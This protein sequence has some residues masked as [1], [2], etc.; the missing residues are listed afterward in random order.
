[1]IWIGKATLAN[2]VVL[3]RGR[4]RLLRWTCVSSVEQNSH[5]RV[6]M[7]DGSSSKHVGSIGGRTAWRNAVQ[8]KLVAEV[9][10][11]VERTHPQRSPTPRRPPWQSSQQ[12]IASHGL[13]PTSSCSRS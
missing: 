10:G 11:I 9:S 6:D 13:G 4:L 3:V 8:E 1:M 12:S 5:R 7:R 2:F